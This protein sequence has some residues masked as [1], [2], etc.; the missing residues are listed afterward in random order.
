MHFIKDFKTSE[1]SC[2]ILLKEVKNPENFGVAYIG[3]NKIIDLEEK[4]KNGFQQLG[5]YRFIRF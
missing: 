4:P 3:N 1:K 5:K 2:K